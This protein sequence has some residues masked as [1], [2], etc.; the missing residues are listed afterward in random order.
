M[1]SNDPESRLLVDVTENCGTIVDDYRAV[2]LIGL[3]G[4]II[5][6]ISAIFLK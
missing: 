2:G 4:F 6:F 1:I 3:S 5:Y